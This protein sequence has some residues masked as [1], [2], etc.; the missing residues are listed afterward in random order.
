VVDIETAFAPPGA[1]G[2]GALPAAAAR[3]RMAISAFDALFSPLALPGQTACPRCWTLQTDIRQPDWDD[4]LYAG[5]S[6][7]PPH[8]PTHHRALITAMA[9]EHILTAAAVLRGAAL[10]DVAARE[11]RV[12]LRNGTVSSAPVAPYPACGCIRRAA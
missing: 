5:R 2:G 3:L 12:D 9:V 4:W 10:P 8:V 1:A 6:P 11:R 7:Q